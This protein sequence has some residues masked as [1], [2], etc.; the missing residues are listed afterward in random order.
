MLRMI[1]SLF[2]LLPIQTAA[3]ASEWRFENFDDGSFFTGT[4]SPPGTKGLML[5]CGERSP[6]GLTAYQTG[7]MEPDI[8]PRDSLR[9]YLSDSLIGEHDGVTQMRQDV[10][11]VVGTTGYRLPV[12]NWNELFWTWEVDLPA[13]DPVFSAISG[14]SEFELRS[15]SSQRII[16]ANG[17][18]AA[19]AAL[20]KHCQTMFTAIGLPW[21]TVNP[22]A[23]PQVTM[24]QV[25]SAAIQAGCGGPSTQGPKTFLSGEI[26]GDGI[27]DVV[28]YWNEITCSGGYPRPFC[29]ASMC[30]VQLFLSSRHVRGERPE[31]L[32]AQG[33]WLQPL[34]NGNMGV[35]TIGS[36]AMCQNRPSCEYLWYWNGHE[37]VQLN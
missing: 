10:L 26:D 27:E 11:L 31:E 17:F 5:L 33:V 28:V 16:T 24:R 19:H 9:L 18:R 15:A 14:Q 29:G 13:T 30:S 2:A 36:L 8:T 21:S 22:A 23:A 37:M 34:S 35:V 7:N 6:R 1:V 4:I 25:A 3:Q 12:V 32:L 20:T